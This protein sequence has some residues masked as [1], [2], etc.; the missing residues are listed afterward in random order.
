MVL[1]VV[2]TF[3][4]VVQGIEAAAG[5]IPG[6]S[7]RGSPESMQEQ[8]QVAREHRLPFFRT[9]EEIIAA[10]AEGHLVEMEGG[11]NYE[12]ADFV[13]LSYVL[14]EAQ[15][16]VE[17]TATRYRRACGEPL[18]VTSAVRAEEEQ[19]PNAHSLS[20]HPA[21]MAVDLRVSQNPGCREW[22][23]DSLL[24][25]ERQDV[26]NAVRKFHPPHYHVAL[27]PTAYATY[28]EGRSPE[29]PVPEE[30][31]HRWYTGKGWAGVLIVLALFGSAFLL[32]SR[33]TQRS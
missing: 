3:A 7:L 15:Q 22:L 10:A 16:F 11:R 12:V 31:A 13:D 27:Y 29:T 9:E 1:P 24:A 32:I 23:E 18:V 19:P 2:L 33:R 6:A 5:G 8:H 20:V 25:L 14:P 4:V 17:R 30:P 21:G 26:L 28:L